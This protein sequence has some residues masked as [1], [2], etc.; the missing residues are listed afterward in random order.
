MKYRVL[1]IQQYVYET[2]AES[3]E[4]AMEGFRVMM[5]YGTDSE[6]FCMK[7]KEPIALSAAPM[8]D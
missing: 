7:H 8:E 5:H 6:L 4:E 1:G 3:E 2:E